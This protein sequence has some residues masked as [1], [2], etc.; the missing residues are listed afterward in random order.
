M[1]PERFDL[2][3]AG[4]GLANGLVAHRLAMLRPEIGVLVLEAGEAP[5]GNHTWSFHDGDLSPDETAW[6]EPFV[7]HRWNDYDVRFPRRSRRIGTGYASV[8]SERF[9][10]VLQ[11][12]RPGLVRCRTRVAALAPD[13]VVLEDGTRIAAGAVLD[14]RGPGPSARLLLG[15]Q[16]FL[17]RELLLSEPHGLVAPTVMDAT[18]AQ[19]DGYRFVY[20]LP[21][22]A[23]RLL[24]EDTYY[25]DGPGLDPAG[26]RRRIDAYVAARGWRA[27]TVLREEEG[28]LPIALGGDIEGFWADRR[29]LPA[30]G[31]AAALFHPT[32]GYSLPDAVRLADVVAGLAD[33]SA[34]A[35]FAATRDHSHRLW[36]ERRFFR[37][38]NRML[39]LAGASERRYEILQ[40]FHR[41]PDDVI[42]RFY[43]ARL[44][45]GDKA[46]ILAGKPPVPVGRALRA[47][48][49]PRSLAPEDAA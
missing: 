23:R 40:H 6:L 3:L 11:A 32:T 13:G 42:A 46:R 30:A 35:L 45:F 2:V 7:V 4:G 20:T 8:T 14:A 15:Y 19:D 10:R 44:S 49:F 37:L 48:A 17:G 38:L 18:V 26:L 43:A 9:A 34:P 12:G 25:A 5:G 28:I 1:A 24:V 27:Q 33:L 16:K 22:D 39:F 31:L 36:R 21:L 47:L 41:L 29:G